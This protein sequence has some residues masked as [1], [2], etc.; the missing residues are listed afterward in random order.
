MPLHPGYLEQPQNCPW[1]PER[2][3]MEEPQLG[4]VGAPDVG[5]TREGIGIVARGAPDG[6]DA[7]LGGGVTITATVEVGT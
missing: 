7:G 3:R 5:V 6:R 4:Q 1:R 2:R